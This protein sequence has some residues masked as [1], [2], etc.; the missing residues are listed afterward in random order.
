ME[1]LTLNEIL[2]TKVRHSDINPSIVLDMVI[3]GGS[4]GK[5]GIFITQM[6]WQGSIL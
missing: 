6:D 3:N 4:T 2:W 5:E 1:D